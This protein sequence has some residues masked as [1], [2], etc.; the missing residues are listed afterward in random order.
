MPHAGVLTRH[1]RWGQDHALVKKHFD[2][3]KAE[4]KREQMRNEIDRMTRLLETN[5]D[6]VLKQVTDCH[7]TT[8]GL[9]DLTS[10]KCTQHMHLSNLPGS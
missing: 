5:E 8:R 6:V 10:F 4:T 9:R 3:E 2:Y 7:Q 1:A